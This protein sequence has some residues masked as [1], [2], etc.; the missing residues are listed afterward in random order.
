MEVPADETR[1]ELELVCV[2]TDSEFN[3]Q[4][5]GYKSIWNARGM[6]NNAWHRIK[7]KLI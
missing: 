3:T 5:E 4:P 6:L 7:I 2:A 1:K